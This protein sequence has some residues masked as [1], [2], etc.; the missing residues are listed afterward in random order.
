MKVRDLSILE[1]ASEGLFYAQLTPKNEN[2]VRRYVNLSEKV[3]LCMSGI[4]TLN[5][6]RFETT[7]S[8]ERIDEQELNRNKKA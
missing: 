4:G 3:S 7:K 2:I 8:E 1:K 6:L 5:S